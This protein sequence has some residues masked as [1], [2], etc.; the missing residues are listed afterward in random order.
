MPLR[1][2][3]LTPEEQEYVISN[4]ENGRFGNAAELVQAALMALKREERVRQ[5]RDADETLGGHQIRFPNYRRIST[6]AEFLFPE[7]RRSSPPILT[8]SNEP[9]L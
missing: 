3:R 9:C 7:R 4:V 6:P 5:E 2:V 1:N 8:D